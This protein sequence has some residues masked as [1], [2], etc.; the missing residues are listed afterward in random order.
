MRILTTEH[1][2]PKDAAK[3]HQAAQI[4]SIRDQSRERNV[5]RVD[6]VGYRISR[7]RESTSEAS[8]S[9][10]KMAPLMTSVSIVSSFPFVS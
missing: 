3:V 10:A 6:F 8:T 2:A 7:C 5:L 1:N 9:R 4:E